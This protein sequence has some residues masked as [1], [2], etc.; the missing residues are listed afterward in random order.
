[1]RKILS[2]AFLNLKSALKEKIF[3]GIVFFFIFLLSVTILLATMGV[4]E[5]I[6]V[7][8]DAGLVGIE[9]TGLLLIIFSFIIS[10]YRE[11]DSKML[12]VYLS[13]LSRAGYLAGKLLGYLLLLFFYFLISILGFGVIL[14]F[15]HAFNLKIF[16]AIYP[17]FLKLSITLFFTL[18]LCIIFS[19]N[20]VALFSSFFVYLSS[21]L[22]KFTLDL[23]VKKGN[24][25]QIV[26]FKWIYHILPNFDKLDLK[27][28][29][30]Y[31]KI[32][33]FAFFFYIT[34][35]SIIYLIFLYLLSYLI[36]GKKEW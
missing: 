26:I 5:S 35:Y 32:P 29:A 34:I 33:N 2:I 4:G 30:V 17:M 36:F 20:L 24:H 28:Q 25:F 21:E 8:K 14:A 10:F 16:I 11:R 31:E 1:M 12:E 3:I 22:S 9:L 7:L 19:S 27:T 18:F 6:K 13:F 23:V 15:K